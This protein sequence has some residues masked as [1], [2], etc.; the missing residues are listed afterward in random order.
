MGETRNIFKGFLLVAIGVIFIYESYIYNLLDIILLAGILILFIG[1]ALLVIALSDINN[2]KSVY[3]TN[4]INNRNNLYEETR[5]ISNISS[6]NPNNKKESIFTSINK[7]FANKYQPKEEEKEESYII[8]EHTSETSYNNTFEYPENTVLTPEST[9]YY[10]ST[11]NNQVYYEE[12]NQDLKVNEDFEDPTS[13]ESIQTETPTEEIY[14]ENENFNFTANY[15]RPEKVTRK[16]KKKVENSENEEYEPIIPQDR[17]RTASIITQEEIDKENLQTEPYTTKPNLNQYSEK[18]NYNEE[19]ILEREKNDNESYIIC[20]HGIISSKEAF[21]LMIKNAKTNVLLEV[22]NLKDL[23]IKFL[24]S[25]SNL[26]TKLIV[27]KFSVD[28]TSYL[29]LLTSLMERGVEVKVLNTVNTSNLIIDN[30]HA[31]IISKNH[32]EDMNYGAV[33]TD[34]ESVQMIKDDFESSWNMAHSINVEI[35]N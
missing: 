10:S 18:S 31:L 25:I 22:P 24:T 21:E 33:Y 30:S 11:N 13:T 6:I 27:Q 17:I 12:N 2:Q 5:R 3:D 4:S 35:R 8:P 15:S 16:P 23:S 19:T 29:L 14:T 1:I 32:E 7:E 28:E 34:S 26:Q 20:E 9:D